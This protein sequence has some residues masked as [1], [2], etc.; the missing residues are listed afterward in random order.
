MKISAL[1]K[2]G[3]GLLALDEAYTFA[4]QLG[5]SLDEPTNLENLNA[6]LVRF[7][8]LYTEYTTG[9]VLDPTYSLP[10]LSYKHNNS[11][12]VIRL[13]REQEQDPMGLPQFIPQ[14]G[15]EDVRN[16]YGVAKLELFYHPA[17][18]LAVEK[19]KLVADLFDFCQYEGIDFLL[20]LIIYHPPGKTLD[21]V[22]FQETQLEAVGELQRFASLLALQYPQDPLA[23]ATL[24]SALDVPWVV[25]SD[26]LKYAEF[27][28]FVRISVENGA[29]GFLVGQTLWEELNSM[30]LED[31]SPDFAAIEKF[32]KTI[33][34]DRVIELMRIVNE[35]KAS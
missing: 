22:E 7:L 25:I 28:E 9:V 35:S 19:K 33:G 11:G 32:L 10:F 17:E 20:K 16:N 34:K 8:I 2:N 15:I 27:K 18:E 3:I 29:E 12:L 6:L 5:L 31:Q 14:W 1:Q 13:G 4:E 23:T 21:K 26:G 24:T 30:R